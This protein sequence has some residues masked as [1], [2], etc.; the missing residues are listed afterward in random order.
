MPAPI[1]VMDL[2][3]SPLPALPAASLLLADLLRSEEPEVDQLVQLLADTPELTEGSLNFFN[4]ALI[5]PR[6][7][8]SDMRRAT[9][10]F[11]TRN[12]I[13]LCFAISVFKHYSAL[14][15][16]GLERDSFWLRILLRAAAA[17][18]LAELEADLVAD[19]AI[20]VATLQSIGMLH[21]DALYPDFYLEIAETW[22]SRQQLRAMEVEQFGIDHGQLSSSMLSRWGIDGDITE[23]VALSQLDEP[24]L[25][26]GKAEKLAFIAKLASLIA[27]LPFSREPDAILQ[28]LHYHCREELRWID[29]QLAMQLHLFR[30]LIDTLQPLTEQLNIS[31]TLLVQTEHRSRDIL[32]PQRI[33]AASKHSPPPLPQ[34]HREA[35]VS[36]ISEAIDPLTGLYNRHAFPE[37]LEATLHNCEF[38]QQP[39]SLVM[40]SIANFPSLQE[41]Y[42]QTH[43]EGLLSEMAQI[44]ESRTRKDDMLARVAD[45]TFVCALP[46]SGPTEAAA[47]ARRLLAAAENYCETAEPGARL[48]SNV[49]TQQEGD[50]ALS[51]KALVKQLVEREPH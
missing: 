14:P 27:E 19:E 15:T 7:T 13:R 35:G 24:L 46:G 5:Q 11:G 23:A 44:I 17:R 21:I 3:H 29:G 12:T 4:S 39:L 8:L 43:C 50:K 42:E 32:Q 38:D 40:I 36:E 20:L 45:A 10:L 49:V 31:S 41:A 2:N 33:D 30:N 16:A 9:V 1:N 48:I 34:K 25:E 37:L 22:P 28:K 6:R 51:A 26:I 18:L 47:I